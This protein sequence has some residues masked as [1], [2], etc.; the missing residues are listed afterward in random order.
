[1][2]GENDCKLDIG[3]I[4]YQNCEFIVRYA[5][6]EIHTISEYILKI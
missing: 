2:D 3:T 4:I 6:L 1:M 5:P